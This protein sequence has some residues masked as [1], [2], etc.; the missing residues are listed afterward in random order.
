MHFS[1]LFTLGSM[2]DPLPAGVWGLS[3]HEFGYVQGHFYRLEWCG[4]VTFGGVSRKAL[5]R[6][7]LSE[8]FVL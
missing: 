4:R 5:L 8:T 7:G 6:F 2:G 1:A 3:V